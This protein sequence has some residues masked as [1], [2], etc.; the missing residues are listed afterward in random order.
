MVGDRDSSGKP[1]GLIPVGNVSDLK[2]AISTSV[3]EHRESQTGQRA[4]DLR[5]VTETKATLSMTLESWN[6]VNL[7]MALR[8]TL[9]QKP[10][11]SVVGETFKGYLARVSPMANLSISAV[12]VKRAATALTAY[13]NDVTPYDYKVNL[14]SGSIKL[15]D[16][17]VVNTDKL[18]TG[19]PAPTAI[20]V[21]VSTTI[22]VANTATAGSACTFT[23]FS[24]ADASLINGKVVRVISATGSGVVVDLDTFGKTITLGTPLSFFD[25]TPLTADYTYAAQTVIDALVLGT[26]EK[27][28]RFEGLNTADGNL[29]VN[30]DVFK[31]AVSPLRELSL[32]SDTVGQFQVEGNVLADALQV[33]GSKFFRQTQL[34]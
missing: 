9:S 14:A 22:T 18:T 17:A 2:I 30:V 19:G 32:I 3:I 25:G 15:N 10:A 11:S 21:G 34:R 33:S 6:K 7:E 4:I 29:P 5:L 23:G 26:G 1:A 20:S 16:G 28:L 27:F 24:G 8:A 31:F 12:A 13:V